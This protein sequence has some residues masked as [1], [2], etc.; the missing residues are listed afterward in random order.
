M[1]NSDIKQAYADAIALATR[2]RTA[3]EEKDNLILDLMVREFLG[4]DDP[5][6][7]IVGMMGF[8]DSLLL[9]VA[10]LS[11]LTETE[12]LQRFGIINQRIP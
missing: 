1:K 7:L 12:V 10:Q 6:K 8:I 9:V 2:Y 5:I 11:H 3:V 4:N